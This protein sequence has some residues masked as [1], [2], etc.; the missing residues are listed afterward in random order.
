[1]L[2]RCSSTLSVSIF[3]LIH[4]SNGRKKS[5]PFKL[6][7]SPCERSLLPFE[8]TLE[9]VF[10]AHKKLLSQCCCNYS[11]L[12]RV[13]CFCF[14]KS[15][16]YVKFTYIFLCSFNYAFIVSGDSCLLSAFL[17]FVSTCGFEASSSSLVLFNQRRIFCEIFSN[18]EF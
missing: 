17:V 12:S 14:P 15:F 3:P 16:Y 1:M 6:L 9:S 7:H 11:S 18:V 13:F 5:V 4:F 2:S 8:E 10:E